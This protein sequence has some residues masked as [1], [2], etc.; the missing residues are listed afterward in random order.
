METMKTQEEILE[1]VNHD[2]DVNIVYEEVSDN[3]GKGNKY[4][5]NILKKSC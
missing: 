2:T 4:A 5:N 1:S 3:T